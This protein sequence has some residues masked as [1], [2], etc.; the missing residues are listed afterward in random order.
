MLAYAMLGGPR[1]HQRLL[2]SRRLKTHRLHVLRALGMSGNSAVVAPLLNHL[3]SKDVI[4]AKVAAH[5]ILAITGLDLGNEEFE[6]PE[7]PANLE[8]QPQQAGADAEADELESLPPLD[9]DD[10]EADLVPPPEDNLPR[11]NAEAITRWWAKRRPSMPPSTRHVLG[12]PFAAT[13][14]LRALE[15]GPL[16]LRR[17][18]ALTLAIRSGGSVW[19]NTRALSAEQRKAVADARSKVTALA[20]GRSAF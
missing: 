10:L 18:W 17:G 11:P 9:E 19:L 1:E 5:G 12:E 3:G 2:E 6:S 7:L 4:E 8:P 16:G 20:P 14:L 13:S 15:S